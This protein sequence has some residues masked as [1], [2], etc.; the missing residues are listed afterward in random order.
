MCMLQKALLSKAKIGFYYQE[1]EEFDRRGFPQVAVAYRFAP[2][3]LKEGD[4]DKHSSS[5]LLRP[6]SSS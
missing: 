4:R 3:V 5:R 6:V 2:R 1:F